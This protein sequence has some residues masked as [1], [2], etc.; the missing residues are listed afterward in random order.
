[1]YLRKRSL[2]TPFWNRKQVTQ[3]FARPPQERSQ[4]SWGTREHRERN[5]MR[6][7]LFTANRLRNSA[8]D[9]SGIWSDY[10]MVGPRCSLLHGPWS[11]R[12]ISLAAPVLFGAFDDRSAIDVL[13]TLVNA[14]E[15][16]DRFIAE[17]RPRMRFNNSFQS[18]IFVFPGRFSHRYRY[19]TSPVFCSI[20][21]D[22]HITKW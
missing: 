9:I 5:C 15:S 7:L 3:D 6:S 19:I 22:T 13:S 8:R 14:L 21:L 2:Y 12:P 17:K 18:R 1:M 11:H 20:F 16:H 4:A 10:I